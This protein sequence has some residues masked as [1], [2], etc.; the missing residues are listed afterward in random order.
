MADRWDALI[1][2]AGVA[3][4]STALGLARAGASVLVLDPSPDPR[5]LA[6]SAVGARNAMSAVAAGPAGPDGPTV[7]ERRWMALDRRSSVCVDQRL[8]P[9]A[10]PWC[11][12][13]GSE[14]GP[15]ADD[16]LR[17]AGV[18][19]RWGAHVERLTRSEDGSVLG[20]EVGG[21]S[22]L[23]NVTVLAG[24]CAEPAAAAPDGADAGFDDR[25]WVKVP[26][27]P[28]K[29]A[30]R[31]SIAPGESVVVD[32]ILG[33]VAPPAMGRGFLLTHPDGVTVG[34]TLRNASPTDARAALDD[35]RAHPALSPYLAGSVPGALHS[36]R[37]RAR[38]APRLGANGVVVVGWESG[39]RRENGFTEDELTPAVESGIAAAEAIRS[40]RSPRQVVAE[41]RRRVS[42]RG[43]LRQLSGAYR[44]SDRIAWNPRLHHAYAHLATEVLHRVMTETG[45]PKEPVR[46]AVEAGLKAARV[47][48][49]DLVWDALRA[50]GSS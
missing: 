27:D 22:E 43:L 21:T 18:S 42:S 8:P 35:L 47:R 25:A 36:A 31:F 45:A 19:V 6:G 17:S 28:A 40:A 46:R 41:Y 33:G 9:S 32:A 39:L 20:A 3:G 37:R 16:R 24:G 7:V 14:F 5:G 4:A 15:W 26:V 49:A 12:L 44:R 29:L 30:R 11:T 1:L 38:G 50:G 23:A 34:V 13:S 2:G 10:S 48:K